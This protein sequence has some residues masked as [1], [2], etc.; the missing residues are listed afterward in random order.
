MARVFLLQ[1]LHILDDDEENVKTLGIYSTREAAVA[2]VDRFRL[3]PGFRDI[4]HFADHNSPGPADGFNVDEY[5]LDQD[6]WADG[7]VTV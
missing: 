1:H 3:L 7:Y 2:A 4:S 5:E 6:N